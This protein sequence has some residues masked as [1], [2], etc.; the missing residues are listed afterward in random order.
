[1]RFK[2]LQG[3]S[4]T[5]NTLP[6][7]LHPVF[8]QATDSLDSCVVTS[9]STARARLGSR[10]RQRRK[11]LNMRNQSDLA[12]AAGLSLR[13]I[14]AMERGE[15]V[16]PTSIIDVELALGWA[17][18]SADSVLSGGEPAVDGDEPD[19]PDP[20]DLTEDQMDS[21]ADLAE[22]MPRLRRIDP[23]LYREAS[24]VL[25]RL[26]QRSGGPRSGER[27]ERGAS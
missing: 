24:S 18:G 7:A 10:I 8:A 3:M 4:T 19:L 25:R 15:K 16:S 14:G 17:A 12:E 21:L 27:D 26:A 1:M 5:S 2:Y 11:A 6:T 23:G 9:R 13:V 22:L 20:A